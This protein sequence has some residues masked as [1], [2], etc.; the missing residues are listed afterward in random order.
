MT[1]TNKFL[2]AGMSLPEA[3]NFFR[4]HFCVGTWLDS[5]VA[6]GHYR[7]GA[8]QHPQHPKHWHPEHPEQRKKVKA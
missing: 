6:C 2:D 8:C 3:M 5:C 4:K 7:G 1:Q